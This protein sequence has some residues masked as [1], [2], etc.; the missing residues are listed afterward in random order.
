[1][2]KKRD[3]KQIDDIAT[4]FHMTESALLN[5]MCNKILSLKAS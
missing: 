3:T 2:G 1:M 4:L 5:I